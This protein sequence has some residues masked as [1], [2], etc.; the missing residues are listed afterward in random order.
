MEGCVF[1]SSFP[2]T[3]G[4]LS[5]TD[6]VLAY[7]ALTDFY[8]W[9][10]LLPHNKFQ[11]LIDPTNQV[12]I[13]LATHWISLEQIMSTICEAEHKAAAKMPAPPPPNSAPSV[14]SI[15][16]LN[17]LNAQVDSEHLAYNQWPMW[18]EEQ[19]HRD[20]RFFGKTM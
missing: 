14:G 11:P 19:L 13:L 10:M 5:L 17:Y 8:T 9:W 1:F 18:V 6:L 7:V 4:L 20:R 2:V 3:L 12:A 15:K 16:W